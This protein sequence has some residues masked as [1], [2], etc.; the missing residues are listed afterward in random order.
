MQ[1]LNTVSSQKQ[2]DPC[3]YLRHLAWLVLFCL[4]PLAQAKSLL[5]YTHIDLTNAE[6]IQL[7]S[8]THGVSALMF[9]EPEC[10]WCFKQIKVINSYL[11]KHDDTINV[12]GLGVN[13]NRQQLKKE[14]WRLRPEFPVYMA[15]PQ[16]LKDLGQ[17]KATPLTLLLDNNG[18]VIAYNRGFLNYPK[19]LLFLKQSG[20]GTHDR[21]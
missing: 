1:D 19:W 20:V 14:S 7:Q 15:D 8:S 17:V 12:I 5:S 10:S 3:Q 4:S 9:F 18:S 13:G 21:S 6:E 2:K 16:L 11:S